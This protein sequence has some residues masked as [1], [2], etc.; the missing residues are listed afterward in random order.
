MH[1]DKQSLYNISSQIKVLFH[2]HSHP[3]M[4]IIEIHTRTHTE[5]TIARKG[6]G[7]NYRDKKSAYY[8]NNSVA[9]LTCEG[10]GESFVDCS[11]KLRPDSN[12]NGGSLEGHTG[13]PEPKLSSA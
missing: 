5:N 6:N 13:G 11:D 12:E 3:L 1:R 2:R 7:D 10:M 4:I 8:E 9:T